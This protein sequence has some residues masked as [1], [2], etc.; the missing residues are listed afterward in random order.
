MKIIDV[1]KRWL[2]VLDAKYTYPGYLPWPNQNTHT[3]LA[4]RGIDTDGTVRG[5]PPRQLSR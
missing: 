1:R 3:G 4:G 2:R 5:T